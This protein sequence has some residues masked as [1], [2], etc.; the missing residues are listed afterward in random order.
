M[1]TMKHGSY[2]LYNFDYF[3]FVSFRGMVLNMG[4]GLSM[5][6]CFLHSVHFCHFHS[7]V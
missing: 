7:P 2:V 4:G 1:F 3:V 5:S 6:I